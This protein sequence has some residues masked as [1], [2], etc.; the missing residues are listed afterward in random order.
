[1]VEEEVKVHI[2]DQADAFEAAGMS[3][4]EAVREAVRQMG[5]PVEAGVALD[6]VHRP[7]MDVKLLLMVAAF[8]ILGL[9]VQYLMG[10]D[11][12]GASLFERQCVFTGAGLIL[13]LVICWLDYSILGRIPVILWLG[14]SAVILYFG[15]CGPV[16]NGTNNYLR[17]VIYLYVP[18]YAG[19][20]YRYRGGSY[21]ALLRCFCFYLA[22]MWISLQAVTIPV[23]LDVTLICLCLTV[24]ALWKNWFRVPK[25]TIGILL[26]AAVVIPAV[27]FLWGM[28]GGFLPYQIQRIQIAVNPG[29]YEQTVGYQASRVRMILQ[30]SALFGRRS[31]VLDGQVFAVSD[32]SIGSDHTDYILVHIISYFGILAGVLLVCLFALFLTRVFR[33]SLRQKNQLGQMAG[34]GCGLVFGVQLFHYVLSN[35]GLG[36][37]IGINLPFFTYGR[38]VALSTYALTGLLLSIYRYKDISTDKKPEYREKYRL[39]IKIERT[40]TDLVQSQEISHD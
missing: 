29:A 15:F 18:L 14:F 7:R 36:I 10:M 11:S 3:G 27:C 25:K 20:L 21:P 12:Y 19:I 38:W 39:R 9:A 24:F 33:V 35:L 4:A 17:P 31:M 34:I 30:A 37:F 28:N 22:S 1:M 40:G 13:M 32:I 26:G 5:D 2:E 8:S 16:I 23:C 6:R